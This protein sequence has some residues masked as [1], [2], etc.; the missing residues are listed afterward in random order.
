MEDEACYEEG[1]GEEVMVEIVGS[2]VYVDGV[3]SGHKEGDF[4]DEQIR[5]L[6]ASKLKES[7]DFCASE[8]AANSRCGADFPESVVSGELTG[9]GGNVVNG[10]EISEQY[11]KAAEI[12]GDGVEAD[13][14]MAN[15]LSNVHSFDPLDGDEDNVHEEIRITYQRKDRRVNLPEKSVILHSDS[16]VVGMNGFQ[17]I[18]ELAERRSVV[19]SAKL[20]SVD[21]MVSQLQ[22]LARSPNNGPEFHYNVRSFF[23]GFRSS[24]VSTETKLDDLI[25]CEDFEFDFHSSEGIVQS[26]PSEQFL[27]DHMKEAGNLRIGAA[28]DF[29]NST[30]PIRNSRKRFSDGSYP[31]EE[32]EMDETVKRSE[33]WGSLPAKLIL[34]FAETK[35]LPTEMKLNKMFRRFGPLMESKT[36]VDHGSG[37]AKVVF[38]RGSD[39]EVAL[40]SS[41]NFNVFGS[42]RVD[43]EI[44]YLSMI[45]LKVSPLSAPQNSKDTKLQ[46]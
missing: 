9:G 31:T 44:N 20:F 15:S 28:T 27:Q 39:A 41:K 11:Q 38:K 13:A 42:V 30:M 17:K 37:H 33:N 45:S 32:V 23:E 1:N 19:I 25:T 12:A 43:Y 6:E 10:E 4:G 8:V 34:R 22:A 18:Y 14:V 40:N 46:P 29:L 3:S 24:I 35:S 5:A 2:D 36:E 16:N 7:V 26:Y 21:D